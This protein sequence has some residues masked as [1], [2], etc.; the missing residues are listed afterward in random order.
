MGVKKL[1]HLLI[2]MP[3]CIELN[4]E[5]KPKLILV[6]ALGLGVTQDPNPIVFFWWNVWCVPF[7]ELNM[8][9]NFLLFLVSCFC[10][11]INHSGYIVEFILFIIKFINQFILKTN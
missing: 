10:F 2:F 7:R 4:S 11:Q 5:S 1:N 9:L 8:I 3:K 6:L